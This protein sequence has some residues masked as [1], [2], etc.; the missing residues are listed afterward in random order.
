MIKLSWFLVVGCWLLV[1]ACWLLVVGCWLL[2]V[3]GQYANANVMNEMPAMATMQRNRMNVK[4]LWRLFL[5]FDAPRTVLSAVKYADCPLFFILFKLFNANMAVDAF[6]T[7][8]RRE[9]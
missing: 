8:I 2:V 3:N 5:F 9:L 6:D 7:V 1:V 4:S